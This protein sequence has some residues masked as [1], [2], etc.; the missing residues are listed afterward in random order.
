ML[1]YLPLKKNP[2]P[3]S[4]LPDS[5]KG[6]SHLGCDIV[7]EPAAVTSSVSTPHGGPG[8]PWKVGP[9]GDSS[10]A[11]PLASIAARS[12]PLPPP[13]QR[14]RADSAPNG[15]RGRDSLD[16][17]QRTGLV[18]LWRGPG[19]GGRTGRIARPPG[20]P[21]PPARPGRAPRLRPGAEIP[22]AAYSLP[23]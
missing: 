7:S 15:P 3:Y 17:A 1:Q 21:E 11:G 2:K 12:R 4:Q 8:F 13:P 22:P 5:L 18:A 20:K 23:K 6:P 16:C 9:G 14:H 19:R 10:C